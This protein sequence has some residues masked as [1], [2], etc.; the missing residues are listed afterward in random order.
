M[1]LIPHISRVFAS[2]LDK[3]DNLE[4]FG[5][6][7]DGF[8]LTHLTAE[9][10]SESFGNLDQ[11]KTWRSYCSTLQSVTLYGMELR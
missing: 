5:L 9:E 7:L 3:F 8:Q 2:D 10:V 6:S 11:L 1:G 4:S